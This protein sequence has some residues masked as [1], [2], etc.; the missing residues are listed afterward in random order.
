MSRTVYHPLLRPDDEDALRDAIRQVRRAADV[1]LAFGGRV[2]DGL[3][4]LSEFTGVHTRWIRGLRVAPGRGLGGYVVARRRAHVVRDYPRATTITHDYDGAT[5]GEG[6]RSVAAVPVLVAGSV[7]GVLFAGFRVVQPIGDHVVGA[8]R[9]SAHR[10]AVEL[11]VRDE[12]DRRLELLQA[13]LPH[14]ERLPAH[15]LDE[16]RAVH[17]DLRAIAHRLSDPALRNRLRQA[18]ER[19][20]AIQDEADVADCAVLST[21]PRPA[22][23]ARELD[24]L[25][26]VALGCANPEIARRL[27]LLPET[28]KA[29]LRSA[30]RKLGVHGRQ[31][32]VA[33]ARRHG[34]L[35]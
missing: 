4:Q 11:T 8:L 19:L 18:G 7:R 33:A 17:A 1:P 10:L 31:Q 34:L 2:S 29:Y 15:Q 14:P 12:V 23:S 6:I 13:A 9:E 32:V 30:T 27:S 28:V 16:I 5:A 3:L 22:L 26:Y 24:V 20:I 21:G 35:P 25:S